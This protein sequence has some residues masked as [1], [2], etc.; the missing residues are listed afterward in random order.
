MVDAGDAFER[1]MLLGREESAVI[2]EHDTER[3]SQVL[4]ERE[5]AVT[6][7]IGDGAARQDQA[8]LDKLLCIQ[9]MNSR[10]RNEARALHQSL[11][12]ELLKL[13]SENRRMG[14]YRS[15]A[16]VTPLGRRALSRKG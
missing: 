12:E 5:E 8:F 3:L 9:D 6:A 13:R 15:G 2:A 4:R 7:F 14:G 16:L 11:K 1:I 10:L